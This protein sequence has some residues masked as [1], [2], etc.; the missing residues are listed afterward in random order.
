[1]RSAERGCRGERGE[2]E[3]EMK[4]N[5][6]RGLGERKGGAV[7]HPTCWPHSRCAT[8]GGGDVGPRS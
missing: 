8:R 1:M 7:L 5:G 6:E 2:R 4:E 3:G